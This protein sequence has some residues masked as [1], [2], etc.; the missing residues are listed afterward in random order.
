MT[1][2]TSQVRAAF[3]SYPST[4]SSFPKSYMNIWQGVGHRSNIS[5]IKALL[6]DYTK[7]NFFLGSFLGRFFCAHWN[8]HHIEKVHKIIQ[9]RYECVEDIIYDLKLL[10]P[11]HNGSLDKRIRFIDM[12]TSV[13]PNHWCSALR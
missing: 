9:T 4:S 10:K 12:Q 13:S 1:T 6:Q 5:K 2:K 11:E 8:R 7:E 3:F